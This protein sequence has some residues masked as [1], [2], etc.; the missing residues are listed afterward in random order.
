MAADK[1]YIERGALIAEMQDCKYAK[2]CNDWQRGVNASVD[3]HITGIKHMPAA[4][5]AP[6]VHGYWK[7]E[8]KIEPQAQNRLYCSVCDNE[9]LAKGDYYEK[10]KYCPHCGARMDGERKEQT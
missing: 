7:W 5:V 9:C 3:I 6:V 4:D 2:P 8:T 10:S 1:E